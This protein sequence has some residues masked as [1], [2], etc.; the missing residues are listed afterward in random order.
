M[1]LNDSVVRREFG[2]PQQNS[3]HLGPLAPCTNL[4]FQFFSLK[5]VFLFSFC[6]CVSLMFGQQ[7]N[8]K[9]ANAVVYIIS[10]L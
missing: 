1:V 6:L 7:N 9:E 4:R 3:H 8:V 5:I 2:R 10:N